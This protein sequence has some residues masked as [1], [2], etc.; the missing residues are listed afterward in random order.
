LN[1]KRLIESELHGWCLIVIG[2]LPMPAATLFACEPHDGSLGAAFV[3]R[4]FVAAR[5]S[6][7]FTAADMGNWDAAIR[8]RGW[9]LREG[10]RW[11]MWYT[12]YDGTRE[13]QKKLGLATS[14]DGLHWRRHPV[15]PIYEQ[16]WVEDMQVVPYEGRYVMFAEGRDDQAHLLTSPDGLNWTR[17][18]ALDIRLVS[19]TP[20]PP[21]P[22]GTPTA[23]FEDGTWYLFYERGDRGVWLATSTDLKTFT[24]VQDE[25]VLSPGPDAYDGRMIAL[26]QIIKRGETY[27]AMYHGTGTPENPRLWCT[28]LAASTDLVRW[29]KHPANPL[30]PPEENKS[31]GLLVHDGDDWRLYTMHGK[32]DLHVPR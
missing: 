18:G 29:T 23:H 5:D 20:I 19:G 32:V 12:G 3:H 27:Y 24:N 25:P 4:G 15:N 31:S 16:H 6:P 28:C 7:V 14:P 1:A 10:D 22:Y 2:L 13:G 8:E 30:L 11:R 17:V 26:N 9:I 21:G